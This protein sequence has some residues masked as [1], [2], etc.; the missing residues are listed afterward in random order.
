ME[1]IARVKHKNQEITWWEDFEE[2]PKWK[3]RE[4]NA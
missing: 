3:P 4:Q 1:E 2:V